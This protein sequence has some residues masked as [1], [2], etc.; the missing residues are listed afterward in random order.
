MSAQQSKHGIIPF[1]L[2]KYAFLNKWI[3]QCKESAK[4]PLA[5]EETS[6]SDSESCENDNS[7]KSS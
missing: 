4:S 1:I 2:A 6:K 7:T 5:V 3:H